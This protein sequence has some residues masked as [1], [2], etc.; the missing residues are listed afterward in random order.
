MSGLNFQTTTPINFRNISSTS[1]NYFLPFDAAVGNWVFEKLRVNSESLSLGFL[2]G[3][4]G[5]QT[6]C[7]AIGDHA[8]QNYQQQNS[9]A[10]GESTINTQTLLFSMHRDYR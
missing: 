8:G 3:F 6:G 2:A 5:Q 4:I 1:Q 10:I 9:I 7:I